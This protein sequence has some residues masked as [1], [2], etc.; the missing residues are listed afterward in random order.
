MSSIAIID[1][2]MGNLHSVA[3]AFEHVCGSSI[4]VT[5]DPPVIESADRVVLPGV[6]AM[7]DCMA[8]IKRLGVDE[9]VSKVSKDRPFLGICVG[10]Q[11]LMQSSEENS[12]VDCLGLF[13]GQVKF[14]GDD[15]RENGQ[16]LKVPHMG[17]NQVEQRDHPLWHGI[18][19]Q[20][21]FYFVHSYYVPTSIDQNLV[22][23]TTRYGVDLSAAIM[24]NNVFATQFHPE[25][26]QHAGLQLLKN[27][28]E[29]NGQ[30]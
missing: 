14:F 15:L 26:S 19:N 23:G 12:G 18:D 7:R 28:S 5:S 1:Y 25:K 4:Q 11:A 9:I 13:D 16:R 10:M 29:W 8:E 21:R 27:F 6:G 20:S 24:R 22:A 2:G 17:W 3:S 30:L